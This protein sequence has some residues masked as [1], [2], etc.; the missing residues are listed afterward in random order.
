LEATSQSEAAYS[1]GRV[2]FRHL[3]KSTLRRLARS[4]EKPVLMALNIDLNHI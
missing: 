3:S 2:F 1:A 4:L